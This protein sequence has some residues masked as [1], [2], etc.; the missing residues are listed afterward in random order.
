MK[1]PGSGTRHSTLALAPQE[2]S[3]PGQLT[4]TLWA[5]ASFPVKWAFGACGSREHLL[6]DPGRPRSAVPAPSGK[7]AEPKALSELQTPIPGWRS[8]FG[9]QGPL[10]GIS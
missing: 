5:S 1:G 2:L 8:S 6:R 7:N 10:L 3:D 4:C 9:E